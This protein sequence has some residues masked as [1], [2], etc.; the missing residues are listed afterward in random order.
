[1]KRT[2][3]FAFSM[4]AAALAPDSWL[5]PDKVKHFFLGAFVQS[6]S[7]SGLRAAG[8]ERGP[9]LA[10]ASVASAGVAVAKELRDHRGRGTAS[11]RDLTWSLAGAAAISPVLAR[12]R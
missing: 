5:G 3:V 10:G 6:V 9:S 2:L 12:T 8:L 11:V 7:F 4:N 1:M